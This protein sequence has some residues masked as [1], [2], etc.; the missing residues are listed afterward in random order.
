[1]EIKL[2]KNLHTSQPQIILFKC[3][4]I[5]RIKV[6]YNGFY[7]SKHLTTFMNGGIFCSFCNKT[8]QEEQN[9]MLLEQLVLLGNMF[10]VMKYLKENYYQFCDF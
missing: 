1:M 10:L 7:A 6:D 3:C 5:A 2:Y 8:L 4:G 9:I